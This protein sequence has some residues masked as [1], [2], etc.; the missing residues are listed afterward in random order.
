[1]PD[2]TTAPAKP[3][4]PAGLGLRGRRLWREVTDGFELSISELEVLT[5]AARCLDRIQTL[6]DALKNAPATVKGSKGQ[7]RPHPLAAELR[8]EVLLAARLLA[9]LGL[10]TEEGSSKWD[11]LSASSRARKAARARWDNRGGKP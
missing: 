5:L 8:S 9:Q 2:M 3:R 7:P 11:G 6:E 10:P 4:A 1:M